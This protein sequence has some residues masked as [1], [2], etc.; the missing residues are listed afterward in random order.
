MPGVGE[1]SL[2][3]SWEAAA[4]AVEGMSTPP[5]GGGARLVPVWFV[6]SG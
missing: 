6:V 5:N 1:R 2:P 4:T 3:P